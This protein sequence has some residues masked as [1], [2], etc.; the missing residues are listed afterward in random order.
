MTSLGNLRKVLAFM[1]GTN[2]EAL[3]MKWKTQMIRLLREHMKIIESVVH[4]RQS[5]SLANLIATDALSSH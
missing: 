1:W 2:R 5:F 3:S 4:L